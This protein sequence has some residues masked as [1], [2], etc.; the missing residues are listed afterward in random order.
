MHLYPLVLGASGPTITTSTP[1]G[2]FEGLQGDGTQAISKAISVT[3]SDNKSYEAFFTIGQESSRVGR[4][5][6]TAGAE[7]HK[8]G[9]IQ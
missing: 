2:G 5:E 8:V 1:D 4:S 3:I 7:T 6:T 9:V